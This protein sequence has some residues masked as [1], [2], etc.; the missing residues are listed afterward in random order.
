MLRTHSQCIGM[1]IAECCYYN[2][3]IN[4]DKTK[5]STYEQK[6]FFS[7]FIPEIKT[8][9]TLLKVNKKIIIQVGSR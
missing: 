1:L 2:D 3:S 6:T 9:F 4:V 8:K 5:Q 7:N